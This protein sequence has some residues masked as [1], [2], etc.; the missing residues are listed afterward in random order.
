MLPL[1]LYVGVSYL[2]FYKAGNHERTP[3]VP[4]H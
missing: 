3:G 1:E 4:G 2:F